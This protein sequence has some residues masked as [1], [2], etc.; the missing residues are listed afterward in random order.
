M[1]DRPHTRGFTLLEILLAVTI[2]AVLATAVYAT[3][4]AGLAGWKRSASVTENL[5]RERIVMETLTELTQSIVWFSSKDSLYNIQGTHTAQ[6]GDSISFVTGS[7][8][9]LPVS[10][11]VASGMRRVTIAM[12]RDAR[13]RPFLSMV[14]APALE[15]ED[16]PEGVAHMLSAA[17]CGFGVR[18]RD[19]RNGTWA[20]KWEEANLIPSAIEYTIAFGANDG[21]TPPVVATRT[22]DL[23][24]AQFALQA[25]GEALSQQ[26]TTNTVTRRDIDT[27]PSGSDKG[28][29]SD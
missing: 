22:V 3:W 12:N 19:P 23:P 7:D 10:E 17:V 20:E 18:Y 6:T 5:Q 14:N 4:S 15:P 28:S 29:E 16:A 13:G 11:Q 26:N 25:L 9:L 8:V 1:S 24:I 21:R 2:L 27:I